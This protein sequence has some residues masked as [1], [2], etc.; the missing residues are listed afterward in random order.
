MISSVRLEDVLIYGYL[1]PLTIGNVFQS[2]AETLL[3][4]GFGQ[5]PGGP[6]GRQLRPLVRVEGTH[7][8]RTTGERNVGDKS[9][10]LYKDDVSVQLIDRIWT[11]GFHETDFVA[12]KDLG[13]TPIYSSE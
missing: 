8:Y 12:W 9:I 1:E 13:K 7:R 3:Q 2:Q 5:F 11:N 10:L 6:W 4:I